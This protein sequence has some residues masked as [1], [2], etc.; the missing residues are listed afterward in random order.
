[1]S[2]DKNDT[3]P[4]PHPDTPEWAIQHYNLML[5]TYQEV[6]AAGR[7]DDAKL[8]PIRADIAHLEK[9]VKR[10]EQGNGGGHWPSETTN[11]GGSEA[12]E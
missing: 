8:I 5:R 12:E 6:V 7:I 9:R 2:D 10:I 3:L 1:M 4:A 11:P